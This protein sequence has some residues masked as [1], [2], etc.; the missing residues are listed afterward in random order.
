MTTRLDELK[1]KHRAVAWEL[2]QAKVAH[3][4]SKKNAGPHPSPVSNTGRIISIGGRQV[5]EG[6]RDTVDRLH[7][8]NIQKLQNSLRTLD[9]EIS[10]EE[11]K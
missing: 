7:R 2:G 9:S 10:K 6:E 11:R 3:E 4:R 8:E 5:A 1:R